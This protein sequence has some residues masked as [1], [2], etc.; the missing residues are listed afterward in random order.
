MTAK[1]DPNTKRKMN[2]PFFMFLIIADVKSNDF[3]LADSTGVV[4]NL[5]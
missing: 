5:V 4:K 3:A 1:T 2:Y